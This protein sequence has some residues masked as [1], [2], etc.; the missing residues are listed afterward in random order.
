MADRRYV[1]GSMVGLQAHQVVEEDGI[2]D[3]AELVFNTAIRADGM[4][5]QGRVEC[6]RAETAAARDGDLGFA[7]D[8]G[9]EHG[10]GGNA[11]ETGFGGEAAAGGQPFNL[12]ADKVPPGFDLAM[13]AI[14]SLMVVERARAG[15]VKK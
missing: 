4:G 13:I 11:G 14:A 6:R 12:A 3:P 10:D 5:E 8:F 9:L 7:F 2:Q 1:G 15:L